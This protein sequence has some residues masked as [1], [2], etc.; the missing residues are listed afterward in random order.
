MKINTPFISEIAPK[1][2][3][4]NEFGLGTMY[5]LEGREKA[6]LIDTGCGV[7]DLKAIVGRLTKKPLTVVLTHGHLDHVGGMGLF[8]KV[9]LNEKD[10]ELALTA[11]R[12][13]LQVYV[14]G[15]GQ[16]GGYEIYDYSREDVREDGKIPE[17]LD[18]SDEMEFDLGGRSVIAYEIS[19]HT[20]GGVAF[21]DVKNR[22]MFSGDCCN[23]NLLAMDN[24][25][26]DILQGLKKFQ[27]LIPKFDQNFNGHVG[28]GINQNC[29]SQ[30]EQVTDDLIHICD[31]ILAGKSKAE[32][33]DIMGIPAYKVSYGS[34]ALTYKN[35]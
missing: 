23:E 33:A 6:L 35:I 21:L 4:I 19:G 28:F 27:T 18:L 22:I 16:M 3:A 15:A 20:S 9:Y 11:T 34:A 5:L 24:S 2:Y 30:P 8:E 25:V 10:R 32:P 31:L 7:C 14:D 29:F 1:T 13:E 26:S 17:F 12:E